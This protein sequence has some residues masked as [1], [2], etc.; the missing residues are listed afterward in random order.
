LC[1]CWQAAL[2]A[3]P[4][5][6]LAGGIAGLL[7]LPEELLETHH[8]LARMASAAML[9][10]VTAR[11]SPKVSLLECMRSSACRCYSTRPQRFVFGRKAH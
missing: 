10:V 3:P 9:Q 6:P 8:R 4:E 7:A 2:A 11:A 5:A 1:V